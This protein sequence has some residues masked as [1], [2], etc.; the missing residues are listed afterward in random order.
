MNSVE[1][2]WND[3]VS[4]TQTLSNEI[5]GHSDQYPGITVPSKYMHNEEMR[6]RMY[7]IHEWRCWMKYVASFMRYLNRKNIQVIGV[8]EEE[9]MAFIEE[10]SKEEGTVGSMPKATDYYTPPLN[11]DSL[12]TMPPIMKPD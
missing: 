7:R 5:S 9:L 3:W 2:F 12:F 6:L 1:E 4:E 11:I 8:T 10:L